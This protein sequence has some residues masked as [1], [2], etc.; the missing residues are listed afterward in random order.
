MTKL[1][2]EVIVLSLW[3]AVAVYASAAVAGVALSIFLRRVDWLPY[4][5]LTLIVALAAVFGLW[6]LT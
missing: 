6:S 4:F 2:G 1:L 5:F 3:L